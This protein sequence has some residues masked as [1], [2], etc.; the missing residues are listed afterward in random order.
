[1]SVYG[2]SNEVWEKYLSGDD[3]YSDKAEL[4][5]REQFKN[6]N[7][8]EC[9]K[10][11]SKDIHNS[12]VYYMNCGKYK[13]QYKQ[14]YYVI[15]LDDIPYEYAYTYTSNMFYSINDEAAYREWENSNTDKIIVR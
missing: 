14:I 10:L 9:S 5:M 6:N 1:M 11:G 13:E 7:F 4:D 8:A 3:V 12:G 2:V 15:E